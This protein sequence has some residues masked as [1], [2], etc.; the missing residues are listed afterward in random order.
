VEKGP[1]LDL[2]ALPDNVAPPE[3]A[4]P[5]L[6]TVSVSTFPSNG[7]LVAVRWC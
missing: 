3:V 1:R 6:D 2:A 4:S 7:W 5:N